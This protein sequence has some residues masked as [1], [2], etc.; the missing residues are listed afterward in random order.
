MAATGR[1]SLGWRARA[2]VRAGKPSPNPTAA[3]PERAGKVFGMNEINHCRKTRPLRARPPPHLLPLNPLGS[4]SLIPARSPTRVHTYS[5]RMRF[6]PHAPASTASSRVP[7]GQN[8]PA[9]SARARSLR[10][11]APDRQDIIPYSD[12]I[13]QVTGAGHSDRVSKRF[14]V[15]TRDTF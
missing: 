15:D 10:A 5:V 14:V 13:L 9:A 6:P 1:K 11:H 3:V 8:I 12:S 2:R 7:R 4:V